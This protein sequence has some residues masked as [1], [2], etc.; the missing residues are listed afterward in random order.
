MSFCLEAAR[1]SRQKGC[2]RVKKEDP[3]DRILKKVYSPKEANTIKIP[4]DI[5]GMI[6]CVTAISQ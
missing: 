1:S 6:I 2:Q 4:Q 5:N 3:E